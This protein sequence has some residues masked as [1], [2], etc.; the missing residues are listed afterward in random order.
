[1]YVQFIVDLLY[2]LFYAAIDV[3]PVTDKGVCVQKS[4]FFINRI[5]RGLH[6]SETVEVFICQ[7]MY[8]F[9]IIHK[10]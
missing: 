3:S 2:C 6:S 8:T 1:M 7:I 4:P 5:N 9:W 10:M